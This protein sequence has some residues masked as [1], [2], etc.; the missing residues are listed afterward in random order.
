VGALRAPGQR[1][2]LPT[3]ATAQTVSADAPAVPERDLTA[4]VVL[5]HLQPAHTYRCTVNCRRDHGTPT[6]PGAVD[7]TFA[8]APTP[9]TPAPVRF[10]W[11]GDVGGQNVCRDRT[12]GYP[13]FDALAA[14][15]D[16]FV[17]SAT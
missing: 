17:G 1:G 14:N 8:T 6:A 4:R 9:D 10:A 15:T 3:A 5:E 12:L 7:L 11:G 16:F 2:G 13:I